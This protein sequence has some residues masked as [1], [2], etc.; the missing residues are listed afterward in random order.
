MPRIAPSSAGA[1]A[2]TTSPTVPPGPHR[3]TRRATRAQSGSAGA[4]RPRI[5]SDLEPLELAGARVRGPAQ[6]VGE[7]IDRASSG[8]IASSP[9]YGL[10]VIASAPRPS[11]RATAW[12]AAVDPMSP[13]LASITTGR[14]AGIGRPQAL[15]RGD[16]GRAEGLEE[17]EVRLDRG[18]VRAR[19]LEDERGKRLDAGQ[20][21]AEA[22]GQ[23]VGI[24]IE[25]E[26]QD[27]PGRGGAS[28]EALEVG[29]PGGCSRVVRLD[30]DDIAAGPAV[31]ARST[32]ATDPALAGGS[33]AAG[34]SDAGTYQLGRD[35]PSRP[36]TFVRLIVSETTHRPVESS[37][38]ASRR[39]TIVA[40]EVEE[41]DRIA[42]RRPDRR[43]RVAVVGDP[44]DL[45]A[46][47][48]EDRDVRAEGVGLGRG[49][50]RAVGRVR[51]R[52]IARTGQGPGLLRRDVVAED[53][54]RPASE[55][56]AVP[57]V[58][59]EPPVGPPCGV[60]M[61]ERSEFGRLREVSFFDAIVKVWSVDVALERI[62]TVRDQRDRLAVRARDVGWR[63]SRTRCSE[64]WL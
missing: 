21:A 15:E 61:A 19:R 28:S 45:L 49:D 33:L 64:P 26:A 10:T 47:R 30:D 44:Q 35:E 63:T 12:R 5:R 18:G 55:L 7:A 8:A 54:G 36:E 59:E 22:V 9:R 46:G 52:D 40:L 58:Q 6:D 37:R 17:G 25:A 27:R 20:V 50:P 29:G 23:A 48:V 53:L 57:D 34:S 14:S 3:W 60:L 42:G 62:R 31:T 24:G 32:V 13:R 1:V 16:P 38:R 43:E 2:P 51:R 41:R 56:A 39:S 4:S 11:N